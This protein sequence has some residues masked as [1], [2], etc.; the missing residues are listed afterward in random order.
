MHFL[1]FCLKIAKEFSLG[2]DLLGLDVQVALIQ[3]SVAVKIKLIERRVCRDKRRKVLR[4]NLGV[5]V[6]FHLDII[7]SYGEDISLDSLTADQPREQ[8]LTASACRDNINAFTDLYMPFRIGHVA[9]GYRRYH[10]CTV[11]PGEYRILYGIRKDDISPAE[12]R[13]KLDLARGYLFYNDL[14][15]IAI[16]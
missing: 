7:F 14:I 11:C 15:S 2:L 10:I 16:P 6:V 1:K 9:F 12:L 4:R 3:L 13:V 5:L 8:E